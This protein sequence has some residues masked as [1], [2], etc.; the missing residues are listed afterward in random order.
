[1]IAG[2]R[3]AGKSTLASLSL[4]DHPLGARLTL[5]DELTL[6]AAHEDPAGLVTAEQTVFI[7]EIQRAPELLLAIK[8]V[9]DRSNRPGQ[10]LLTGSANVL[11]LPQVADSLPGRMEILELWPFSQGEIEGQVDGFID[12]AFRGW[13][14]V[15]R[16]TLTKTDYLRR[17]VTGGFPEVVVRAGEK[18]RAAWFESYVQALVQRDIR[19]LVGIEKPQELRQLL[20]LLAARSGQLLNLDEVA[21]DARMAP[22]TAR[23]Y[24]RVLQAAYIIKVIPGWATSKTTRAIRAPKVFFC[25]SGLMCHL[26]G[27]SA[28]GLASPAAEAGSVLETFVTM[29]LARQLGWSEVRGELFHFRSKD[30]TEV[31]AVIEAA[32]GGIIGIEVK[33]R[34]TVRRDD[35][36]PLRLLRAKVGER[37]KAGLLLYTGAE[38]LSFGDQLR[39]APMS[40]LW[41][42]TG[43][44]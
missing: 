17:A 25:D 39:C 40:A 27:V 2:A 36:G 18:R 1:M 13:P 35:F 28:Q 15:T 21:R 20:R 34:A 29:E 4:G 3:Q 31:D 38:S 22:T 24:V 42:P 26:L 14:G 33:A 37:F 8:A 19:D 44:Q 32:D 12:R 11:T 5:D 16:T 9:V 43:G 41:A 10:F 30:G 23:R 6:A 7:D